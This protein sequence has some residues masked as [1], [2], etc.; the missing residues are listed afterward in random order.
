[1]KG[2]KVGHELPQSLNEVHDPS[3]AKSL[4]RYRKSLKLSIKPTLSAACR[5][6]PGVHTVTPFL[7]LGSQTVVGEHRGDVPSRADVLSGG[8]TPFTLTGSGSGLR[9]E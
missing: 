3:I 9:S 7:F 4:L 6:E 8:G 1:M 2:W 5:L